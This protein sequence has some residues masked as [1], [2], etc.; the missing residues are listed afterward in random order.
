MARLEVITGPMFSG[1]S[2]ELIRRINLCKYAEKSILVIKP[3][4]DTRNIQTIAARRK[5]RKD[6]K[7][8]EIHAFVPA[9]TVNSA[10]ELGIFM[11][12][13]EP[14]ILVIDESQFFDS[15]LVDEIRKL[16]DANLTNN[17]TIIASGLNMNY[18]GEPFGP[19]PGLMAIAHEL[20]K[21]KAVCFKCKES[22]PTAEM[23]YCRVEVPPDG[24]LVGDAEVY[25]A[26]CRNCHSLPPE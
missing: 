18:R 25:E 17:F 24:V 21:C 22:P 13:Y 10:D 16:L 4:K 6:D 15:W 5:K 11:R 20:Q 26:R 1:K 9:E 12:A 7:K 8:F 23:T 3:G 2:E 14:D 19:T